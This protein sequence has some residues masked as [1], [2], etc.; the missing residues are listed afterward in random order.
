[1][2]EIGASLHNCV[3]SYVDRV[4]KR[5]CTIIYVRK[6]GA[7]RICIEV[8]DGE[9]WQEKT[10]YNAKPSEEEEAALLKWHE[11]HSLRLK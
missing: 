11:R 7:Y 8:R 9:I 3:A 2:C 1:M 6:D 4:G 5:E 10:N